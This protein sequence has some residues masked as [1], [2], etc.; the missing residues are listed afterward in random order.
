MTNWFLVYVLS[1]LDGLNTTVEVFAFLTG[2]GLALSLFSE[3]ILETLSDGTQEDVRRWRPRIALACVACAV[4][5]A[6][7]PNTSDLLKAYVLVEGSKL[8]TAENAQTATQEIVKRVDAL[9]GA[10]TK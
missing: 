7:L 1:V 2:L 5:A 3:P 9:I 6:V 10:I 8:V 4:V